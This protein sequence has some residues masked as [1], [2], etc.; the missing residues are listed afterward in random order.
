MINIAEIISILTL[1]G[2]SK[3][4]PSEQVKNVL[5]LLKYSESD[6]VTALTM[7]KSQGWFEGEIIT[8]PTSVPAQNIVQPSAQSTPP[9]IP[10]IISPFSTSAQ[11][12]QQ[13]TVTQ[14]S[15]FTPPSQSPQ[16]LGEYQQPRNKNVNS[17]VVTTI[18]IVVLLLGAGV[19]YAYWQKMGP[20]SGTTYTESNIMS[21]ILAKMAQIETAKYTASVSLNSEEREND[22]TP[23][24]IKVSNQAELNKKYF[25]DAQRLKDAQNIISKLNSLV[26][27]S[28]YYQQK[29]KA[30]VAY[31]ATLGDAVI[32]KATYYNSNLSINDPMTGQQYS[33]RVVDGG[34][35]FELAITVAT[36]EALKTVKRYNK[37]ATST[38]IKGNTIIFTK[39]SSSYMYM[40][41]EPPKPFL[42]SLSEYMSVL[43][44]DISAKA[45]VSVTSELKDEVAAN[46]LF[47]VNAEGDF[48]DLTYKFNADAMKKEK[49]YYLKINN[50]PSLFMADLSSVKNK[51]IKITPREATSTEDKFDYSYSYL[52]ELEK[53]I[54][55][56][57]GKYRENRIKG[58]KFLKK[59]A[60]VADEEKL[61]SF[62]SKP[63]RE[64]IDGRDLVKYELTLNKDA[65]LPFYTKLQEEVA[66]DADFADY[67][68]AIDQGLIDY[69]K[70]EEFSQVYEYVDK[71]N[72]FTLWTDANGF[73][74][75]VENSMRIVPPKSKQFK[76]TFKLIADDINKSI[77]IEAPADSIL[78]EEVTKNMMGNM[79][80][81]REKGITASIKANLAN[82]RASAE[83][84][85]DKVGGFGKKPFPL[86]PCSA[87]ADTMFAE[88]LIKK[89]I[90]S[91]TD[92]NASK[93][94][95]VSTVDLT[96]KVTAYAV[97][98]PLPTKEGFS[99]CVDS[100]G[101]AEE[102]IDSITQASCR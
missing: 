24:E 95:C 3:T 44:N 49:D 61:I 2:L 86:G 70:S 88:D 1:N 37:S 15:A 68:N 10:T 59:V 66:N 75:I 67:R 23:F 9:T 17:L 47:N 80:S 42:A 34:K 32:S 31:P 62:R 54:P 102:I 71:N 19:G 11:G 48:G 27:Y 92:N 51:W 56:A 46:W 96:G 28:Q 30:F 36:D 72:K 90:E 94:T 81:A 74:A 58:A 60:S 35:D 43:P 84:L 5:V 26:S 82:L 52:S 38:T 45:S 21:G 7:L 76:L 101:T 79:E 40:S 77:N 25:Y 22:A 13:P 16:P 98:V 12:V 99:F 14:S 57:E 20:F 78:I 55:K 97:S 89:G 93:A 18:I 91:A 69:L 65:I 29:D 8:P 73:P 6:V 83:L 41:S 64:K 39:N 33:Y 63:V 87:K 53:E 50:I 85:S 4:S 100:K